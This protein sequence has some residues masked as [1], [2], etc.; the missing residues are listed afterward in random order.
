MREYMVRKEN[1]LHMPSAVYYQA[2]Y[3]VRDYDR[4]CNEYTDL[5]HSS[6]PSVS[7]KVSGSKIGDPTERRAERLTSLSKKTESIERALEQIPAEYQKPV[8]NNVRYGDPYPYTASTS[9]WSRWRRRFL[10]AVALN[11]DLF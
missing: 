6:A 2:L 11:L 9:T 1:A 4:L 10:Y 7:V 8:F 5:L 3:A